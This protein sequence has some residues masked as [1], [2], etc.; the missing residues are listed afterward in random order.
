MKDAP[1]YPIT[2]PCSRNYH[3]SYVHNAIYVPAIQ[4]LRPDQ[5]LAEH[6]RQLT[7]KS[8]IRV[9]AQANPAR[10]HPGRINPARGFG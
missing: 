2:Q 7:G 1:I 8:R 6:A 5:R 3:A 4:Q 9:G 10:A